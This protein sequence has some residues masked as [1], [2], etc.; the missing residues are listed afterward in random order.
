VA[1]PPNVFGNEWDDR[2][3]RP[4]WRWKRLGLSS[5]L[6]AEQIGAS[7]YELEPG[8]KTWPYHFHYGEEEMV[9]VLGGTPTLRDPEGERQL[10]AGDVV[11]FKRGP[12]GGHL[13]RNDTDDP[14]RLLMISSLAEVDVAVF[15][16]SDKIVALSAPPGKSPEESFYLVVPQNAAVDY[17]EGEE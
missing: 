2:R 17:F 14:V 13:L 11:L 12:E 7:L 8:Q 5:R 1:G 10:E 4:G 9:V 16:D 3:D 6:H 15:P